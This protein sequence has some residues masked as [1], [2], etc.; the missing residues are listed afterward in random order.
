[1]K[2][3]NKAFFNEDAIRFSQDTKLSEQKKR[4]LELYEKLASGNF[5]FQDWNTAFN[6]FLKKYDRFLYSVITSAILREQNED[7]IN[8]VM[9][10]I[11]TV[12]DKTGQNDLSTDK[13][14]MLVKLYDHC[15]LANTQ[16]AVYN[17][18][19]QDINQLTDN[20]IRQK[21]REYEKE[22]TTQLI[23]LVS[24]FTALSFVIFGG[25]SVLDNLLQNIKILAPLKTLLV[26]DVWLMCMSTVFILFTKFIFSLTNKGNGFRWKTMLAIFNIIFIVIFVII[27][28]VIKQV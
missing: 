23:S 6:S 27:L 17:Q 7:K 26:A 8:F 15:N 24:I 14:R 1:M 20:T 11:Q 3:S 13:Y 22:I 16:K 19:K 21:V 25:I 5:D 28:L 4:Q 10:N 9:G 12:L 2:N 18:T